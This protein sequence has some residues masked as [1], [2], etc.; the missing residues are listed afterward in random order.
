MNSSRNVA[1]GRSSGVLLHP[2]SLPGG[3]L[4]AEAFRFIDWLVSAGQQWWQVLPLGPPDRFGSPYAGQSAF[5]GNPG[6]LARPHAKVTTSELEEFVATQRYWAGGWAH[7]G[8][9][10]ALENQVRFEK[11]WSRLRRHAA[12][13]GIRILGDIPFYVARDGAD[14]R[15]HPSLFEES[16]SAGVPPDDWSA[17]GQLWSSPVYDW[18]AMR[19]DGYRWWIERFRRM[20]ELVDSV[21]I[22]HF[23]GFVAYWSVPRDHRTAEIGTWRKGPGVELFHCVQA[24]LGSLSFVAEN[25]GAITP[26]VERVRNLLDIPGT[27]V[28]QFS[29]SESMV[30]RPSRNYSTDAVVY[31]GTH[32]NDTSR[33][34]WSRAND[35]ERAHVNHA[36][37][38]L[39]ISEVEP[40]W[41]LI[42]LAL[43]HEANLCVIP[44][45]DLLGL[46]SSARMNF[47]G[48]TRGNWHWQLV[49]GMLS[50]DLAIRMRDETLATNR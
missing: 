46:G 2:T 15:D 18:H 49:P 16:Q 33:G 32:D 9:R 30:N 50:H 13:N 5:A 19:L 3:N 17:T 42:R 24:E 4:G 35:R 39:G 11:E 26:A 22:D 7:A 29:F 6:L 47:P 12:E 41:K 20:Y 43:H 34:W 37:E 8:G 23:R 10:G 36:L 40:H 1:S 44:V 25:L 21:R 28:L 27:V 38:R 48:R 31:T 14:V 45:Q